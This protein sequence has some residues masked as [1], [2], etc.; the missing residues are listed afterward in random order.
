MISK[1]RSNL[2]QNKLQTRQASFDPSYTTLVWDITDPSFDFNE[3]SID[4]GW[5]DYKWFRDPNS[6]TTVEATQRGRNSQIWWFRMV[7]WGAPGFPPS[8]DRP[9]FGPWPSLNHDLGQ[10]E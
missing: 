1:H 3:R 10:D 6:N 4:W 8:S 2:K 9:V 5:V 7:D